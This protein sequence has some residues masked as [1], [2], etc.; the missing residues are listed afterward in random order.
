MRIAL[1]VVSH[2]TATIKDIERIIYED[3]EEAYSDLIQQRQ[4]NF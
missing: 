2:K 4:K 3:I 1:L